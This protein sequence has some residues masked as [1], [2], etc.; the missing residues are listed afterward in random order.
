MPPAPEL[1]ESVRRVATR[2]DRLA[3][4]YDRES[5]RLYPFAADRLIVLLAP[6]PG[7]KILDVAAGTGAVTFAAAQAVGP[8]GRVVAID[9]SQGMLARLEEKLR[10]FRLAH[11]DIHTM[12][13]GRLEFR[14]SY[15]HHTVCG[16][17]LCF[18]PDP[19]RA[20]AEWVRVTRPGGRVLFSCH[21]PAAFR[22]MVERLFARLERLGVS[23]PAGPPALGPLPT[24]EACHAVLAQAGLAETEVRTE[25]FGYHLSMEAW[26]EIIE[27]GILGELIDGLEP[28]ARAWLRA[29]HLEDIAE[30]AGPDGL[31]LEAQTLL[32]GGRKL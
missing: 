3:P 23:P 28:D 31:W 9:V 4:T 21:G 25:S 30:L 12:D 32:A 22:P 19:L 14:S 26:W 10:H 7:E 17:G 20:L 11:V 8:G 27:H 24:A 16:F 29:A 1:A 18:L 6:S 2:F 5:Q 13:A 15:F